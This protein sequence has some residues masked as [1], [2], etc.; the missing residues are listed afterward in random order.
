MLTNTIFFATLMAGTFVSAM[1][2]V[3]P[4]TKITPL[5]TVITI[6]PTATV[7]VTTCPS[8][9]GCKKI[10]PTPTYTAEPTSSCAFNLGN[11]PIALYVTCFI[12]VYSHTKTNLLFLQMFLRP[13]PN[14]HLNPLLLPRRMRLPNCKL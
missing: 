13:G 10:C 11:C 14:R 1:P 6:R 8:P 3:A 7:T 9:D 5:P 12:T 4:I 2:Q